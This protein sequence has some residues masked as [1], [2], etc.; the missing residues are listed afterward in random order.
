MTRLQSAEWSLHAR[1]RPRPTQT[2]EYSSL[3]PCSMFCSMLKGLTFAF[4]HN[5]ADPEWLHLPNSSQEQQSGE[6]LLFHLP[7]P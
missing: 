6:L 7:W 3:A 5:L 1:M 2:S 4:R